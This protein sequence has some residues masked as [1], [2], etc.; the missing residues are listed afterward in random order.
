MSWS[1]SYGRS[2]LNI[3]LDMPQ[4]GNIWENVGNKWDIY[5]KYVGNI[6]KLYGNSD[7]PYETTWKL[8]VI[9]PDMFMLVKFRHLN[10]DFFYSFDPRCGLGH[11]QRIEELQRQSNTRFVLEGFAHLALKTAGI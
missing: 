2:E 7:L 9:F 1:P 6:W 3:W 8:S 5:V 11:A 4:D 10:A